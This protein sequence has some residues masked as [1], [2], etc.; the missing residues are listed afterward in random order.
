MDSINIVVENS[1]TAVPCNSVAA[2]LSLFLLEFS[3]LELR[4]VT[5]SNREWLYVEYEIHV[6]ISNLLEMWRVC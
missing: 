2:D 5:F 4:H 1:Q 6:T 3:D